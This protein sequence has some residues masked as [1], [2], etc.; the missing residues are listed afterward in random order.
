MPRPRK[1]RLVCC[2]PEN[3]CFGP[4]DCPDRYR[5]MSMKRAAKD[6]TSPNG[7]ASYVVM[8]IDEYET[9]RLI[10]LEGYTQEACARQMSVAR[11]TVQAAYDAARKKIA[12]FV[13]NGKT[14]LISGGE[15]HICK[16]DAEGCPR[17]K[18]RHK[19][20]SDKI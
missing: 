11:T 10:D 7:K 12:Q 9:I 17:R 1:K 5:N 2:L 16:G 20:N 19:L 4:I 8:T 6:E 13:V 14:L 18:C 15:Y 3:V